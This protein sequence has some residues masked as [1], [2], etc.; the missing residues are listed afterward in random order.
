[1]KKL[2]LIALNSGVGMDLILDCYSTHLKDYF[3]TIIITEK[4]FQPCAVKKYY[5]ITNSKNH[6]LMAKDSLNPFIL[7]RLLSIIRKEAPDICYFISAHPLNPIMICII[8]IVKLILRKK[9]NIV[10]HIH[11]V[12]PHKDTKNSFFID[13][14]QKWQIRTS[15]KITVYGE[16]LKSE[17]I[18]RFSL[19]PEN[20][21]AVPHGVNRVDDFVVYP[22]NVIKKYISFIG[23]I[24]RYKG[25]DTFLDIVKRFENRNDITFYLGGKGDLSPYQ[26]KIQ[27]L[28]NLKVENR[29]LT[30]NEIDD[31]MKKSHV[32]LLPYIDASQSGVAPIAYYNGCPVIVTNVGG[33]SECVV[34]GKTGF[35]VPPLDVTQISDRILKIIDNTSLREKMGEECFTHYSKNLR[36]AK[37]LE[38]VAKFIGN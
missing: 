20:I 4:S 15:N 37:I 11:D 22:K 38:I 24:D 21:L 12:F 18:R 29:I 3:D 17:I 10:S 27:T 16:T 1:M 6:F 7:Y 2:F 32:V 26:K 28:K 19:L 35:I 9:I 25:I 33:L 8:N 31:I 5:G 23:R 30:N 36:W 34:E 13:F 14:F